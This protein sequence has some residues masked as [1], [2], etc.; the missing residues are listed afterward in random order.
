M[1]YLTDIHWASFRQADRFDGKKFE[2]LVQLLLPSVYPGKWV[3]TKQSWDGK[4]DFV[5]R[6][7]GTK[8]WA[9]CKM[10]KSPLSINIISPTLVMALI[11]NATIILIF[12]YS[13]LNDNALRYLAQFGSITTR[14]IHVF[15]D[16]ELESLI[17][18][19]P[20]SFRFFPGFS[21]PRLLFVPGID[22]TTRVSRDPD[23]EYSSDSPPLL[24]PNDHSLEE[25]VDVFSTFALDIFVRGR[26]P[27]EACLKLSPKA[28]MKDFWLLNEEI[29]AS[30]PTLDIKVDQSGLFFYRLFLKARRPGT[31][32]LPDMSIEIVESSVAQVEGRKISVSSI[33]SAP[34]IGSKFH[35]MRRDF[36]AQI[37]SRSRPLFFDVFGRSGTGKSRLLREFRDELFSKRF[38]VFFF[39]GEGELNPTYDIFIRKLLSRLSK[40]PL[41]GSIDSKARRVIAGASAADAREVVTILYDS[42]FRPST[43]RERCNRIVL[44]LIAE[45]KAALV[46]DNL[47]FFDDY[48]AEFIL[49]ALS[50]LGGTATP[51]VFVFGINTDATTSDMST[52]KLHARLRELSH[53]LDSGCFSFEIEGFTE[54]DARLFLDQILDSG[55]ESKSRFFSD[56]YPEI[57]ASLIDASEANPLYLEQI[58]HY[59]EDMGGL[60]RRET[61]LYIKDIEAFRLALLNLPPSTRL[62][63]NKRWNFVRQKL[64]SDSID[65][66]EVL[67][68]LIQMPMGFLRSLGF[69]REALRPLLSLGLLALTE[70]NEARFNHRQIYLYFSETYDTPAPPL[71]RRILAAT[72]ASTLENL[73][74]IQRLLALDQV[75]ELKSIDLS[76]VAR[77]LVDNRI[78]GLARSRAAPTLLEIF[79]R[80]QLRIPA[81]LELRAIRTICQDFKRYKSFDSALAAFETSQ[82][83]LATRA[84][85]YKK[86]GE[87]YFDFTHSHANCCFAVHADH[88]ALV[89]LTEAL[90]IIDQF[91]FVSPEAKLLEKGKILNRLSV[92]NK[93]MNFLCEA[94]QNA[95][96]ALAIARSLTD[97]RLLFKSYIDWGYLFYGS[98]KSTPN[99]VDK[100]S[101]ACSI[102]DASSTAS[103][104][105]GDRPSA[106]LHKAQLKV[107]ER[108][109]VEALF[110]IED[111]IK[112]CQRNLSPFY[113]IKLALLRIVAQLAWDGPH[114]ELESLLRK[115]D[116]IE[117]RAVKF[118]ARRS[119][120]TAFYMRAKLNELR[121]NI[122]H[123][124]DNYMIAID[125]LGK[126]LTHPRMWER[127]LV[128][129]DDLA[130]FCRMH[131]LEGELKDAL[132]NA[133]YPSK[134]SQIEV[135]DNNLQQIVQEFEPV[136]TFFLERRNLP[137]P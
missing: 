89:L 137:C 118:G 73:Y 85:R 72:G 33:L 34:L 101:T 26:E 25:S 123:A 120:W 14:T 70:S 96:G 111:G 59:A 47:Q 76:R 80:P 84:K 77:L 40:L 134:Y 124:I 50:T 131:G 7:G 121:G 36:M 37:S 53:P 114:E 119:Y 130:Y 39:N 12:S 116:S 69:S 15:D 62:L 122:D 1:R 41:L 22:I 129:L 86:T 28:F 127:H 32:S 13:R 19:C 117:D 17:L 21:P 135:T 2:D 67:A 132:R 6:E 51:S 108:S 102:F 66:V 90:K 23:I 87:S 103:I 125:Q 79:S 3:R 97:P 8:R 38:S 49:Y 44:Q 94:E 82:C 43:N 46:I 55:E 57:A 42:S 65:L 78:S 83:T 4:K 60:A 48:V 81:D 54:G 61:R 30:Q 93:T 91:S 52:G 10:Y 58:L 104:M 31:I 16:E 74:P 88:R 112:Y 136:S 5:Q 113:E 100:W 99:L 106:F 11:D 128:F 107:I 29:D 68:F 95:Q 105:E 109:R 20:D 45:Q 126:I 71:A 9:E 115:V 64:P 35:S 92:A 133:R 18:R 56:K 75:H 24:D 110:V 63:L 98:R 27:M